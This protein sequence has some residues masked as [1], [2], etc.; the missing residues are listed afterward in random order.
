MLAAMRDRDVTRYHNCLTPPAGLTAPHA[1]NTV[2]AQIGRAAIL[3]GR[4]R[5]AAQHSLAAPSL[6]PLFGLRQLVASAPD[7]RGCSINS[8]SVQPIVAVGSP[9]M[10]VDLH[11]P[12]ATHILYACRP[13]A[14]PD[15]VLKP[16]H[17][18]RQLPPAVLSRVYA[19]LAP[20]V[21]AGALSQR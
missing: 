17:G 8:V 12:L 6:P 1:A 21:H 7:S 14:W 19:A 2:P 11:P 16:S 20:S 15:A 3:P 18:Q 13:S 5:R 10:F 9:D 4:P